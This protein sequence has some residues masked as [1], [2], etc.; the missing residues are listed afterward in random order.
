[1]NGMLKGMFEQQGIDV[2]MGA[3]VIKDAHTVTV[4]DEHY[5]LRTLS[6]RQVSTVIN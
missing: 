4:N 1:M 6:L 2:Y 5:K 3:G